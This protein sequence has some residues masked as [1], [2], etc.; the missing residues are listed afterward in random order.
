[1][2]LAACAAGP[3]GTTERRAHIETLIARSGADVGLAFRTLD[4]RDELLIQPDVEFHA[5]STMKVP[6]MIELF[7]KARAGALKLDDRIPVANEFHSI[8]DGSPYKLAVGDDSD[9]DV[10][11]HVGGVMSYRD[12]CE[13]M[14]TVSSN[15]ATNLLIER[16]GA[17]NVQRTTESL[18]APGMHVLRGVEDDKAF[19]QGLNNTTTARGLMTLMEKIAKGEAVDKPSSDE[20]IAILERQHFNDRI[21]AGL[22]EGTRVAHKTGEI[23]KIQHDAAIVFAERP[24]VLVILVRGLQDARKGSALAA[25]ISRV[26]YER[27]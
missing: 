10:Y 6:V 2:V 22:P 18:G 27:R 1:M 5:A 23:T 4:G 11:K 15:F 20:M 24:Y 16:L 25:D 14:I 17:K 13:A 9:A 12:L 3:K 7:R 21:P 19:R 8:V 26:I